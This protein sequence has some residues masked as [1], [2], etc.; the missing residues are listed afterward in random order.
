MF[1]SS[2]LV[3]TIIDSTQELASIDNDVRSKFSQYNSTKN[4]LAS[5]QRK[6]TYVPTAAFASVVTLS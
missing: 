4:S 2:S 6:Q 5:A 1:A 3:D